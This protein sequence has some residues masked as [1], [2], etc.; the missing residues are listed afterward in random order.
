MVA[1]AGELCLCDECVCVRG[2]GRRVYMYMSV[3][4]SVFMNVCV[5][6]YCEHQPF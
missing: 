1:C 5:C 4:V 6:D 2:G 3:D